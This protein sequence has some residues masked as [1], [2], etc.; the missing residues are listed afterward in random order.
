MD[1]LAA[2]ERSI[3]WLQVFSNS[4]VNGAPY[5]GDHLPANS[6]EWPIDT[7][8]QRRLRIV[9]RNTSDDAKTTTSARTVK[10]QNDGTFSSAPVLDPVLARGKSLVGYPKKPRKRRPNSRALGAMKQRRQSS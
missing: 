3:P 8:L 10:R 7:Y 4:K 9:R 5:R 6:W 2:N 1:N